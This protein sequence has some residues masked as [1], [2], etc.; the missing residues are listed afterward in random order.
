MNNPLQEKKSWFLIRQ[1]GWTPCSWQGWAV[2]LI[3]IALVIALRQ[4]A[5]S[6][7]Y[8]LYVLLLTAG[9]IGICFSKGGRRSS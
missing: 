3:F 6:E 1:M 5:G 8:L 9:L 7:H 2:L 4:Q